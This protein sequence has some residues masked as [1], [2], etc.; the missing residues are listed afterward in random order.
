[1]KRWLACQAST[2]LPETSMEPL[3]S[4]VHSP[5]R[6]LFISRSRRIQ[7]FPK[8]KITKSTVCSTIPKLD[9]TLSIHG[10]PEKVKSD[11]G[12]PFQSSEFK[13]FVEYAG[14]QHKKVTPESPQANKEAGRFMLTLEKEKRGNRKCTDFCTVIELSH[15]APATVLFNRNI[16]TGKQ[17]TINAWQSLETS[18]E[19][20][21]SRMK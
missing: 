21:K 20:T 17:R 15:T 6:R 19:Q 10:I 18:D 16:R 13:S 11:N 1:M 8:V 14:F 7:S 9:K 12:S 2:H 5:I 4:V 3:T